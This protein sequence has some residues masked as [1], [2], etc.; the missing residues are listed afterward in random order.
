MTNYTDQVHAQLLG[1]LRGI[2]R[3]G[4]SAIADVKAR[5]LLILVAGSQFRL[6]E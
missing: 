5:E 4:G 3:R 6:N 2:A 1:S